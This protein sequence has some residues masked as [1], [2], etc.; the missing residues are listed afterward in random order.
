MTTP[1]PDAWSAVAREYLRHIVP[2]F[3]PAARAL[4]E[5]AGIGP[6]DRVLDIA[7]G[8]GTASFEAKALGAAEV[9]GIDLAPGM[10]AL[11]KEAASDGSGFRFLHGDALALPVDDASFDVAISSF[12]MIFAPDGPRATSE[13]VR[14]LKPLGRMGLLAWPRQGPIA[15]YYALVDRHLSPAPASHDPFDWGIPDKARAWL[16]PAFGELA[17]RSIPVPFEAASPEEAWRILR[18]STGRIAGAYPWVPKA[19]QVKLDEEMT[20]FF[21]RWRRPDGIVVWPREAMLIRAVRR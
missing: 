12:G 10:L 17:F 6:G 4:C 1:L 7:C 5:F 19:A 20:G 15:E 21:R 3:R 11:A 13:L 16:E 9:T 14:V 18:S 2:G 8:P